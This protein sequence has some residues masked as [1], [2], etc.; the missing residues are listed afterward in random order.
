MTWRH[1]S[2]VNKANFAF[3]LGANGVIVNRFLLEPHEDY[4]PKIF[5]AFL[6]K[7]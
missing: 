2:Q 7:I 3:A 6:L 5:T 4:K 1:G